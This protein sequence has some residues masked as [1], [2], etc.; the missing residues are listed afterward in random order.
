M[1]PFAGPWREMYS[2]L[3]TRRGFLKHLLTWIF[4]VVVTSVLSMSS[5]QLLRLPPSRLPTELQ[6]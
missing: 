3:L 4:L 1:P 6:P 5:P 2:L